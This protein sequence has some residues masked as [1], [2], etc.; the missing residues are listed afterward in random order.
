[1]SPARGF[2]VFLAT[3]TVG[4]S[5]GG[6]SRFKKEFDHVLVVLPFARHLPMM[7]SQFWA[8]FQGNWSK[9]VAVQSGDFTSV[10]IVHRQR[11]GRMQPRQSPPLS[12]S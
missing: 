7:D 10:D 8:D 4:A 1:M 2:G 9:Q 3:D 5:A 11:I 12:G 6:A